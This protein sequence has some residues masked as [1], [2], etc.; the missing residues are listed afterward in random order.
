MSAAAALQHWLSAFE[1]SKLNPPDPLDPALVS[2]IREACGMDLQQAEL[3][4]AGGGC[5]NRSFTVRIHGQRYFIKLNSADHLDLF[6][7]EADG[8]GALARC[9]AFRVPSVLGHGA[10]EQLA[11]LLLEHIA[12]QPL[13]SAADAARFADAL[14]QLHQDLD[15]R[16]GWQR[17]NYIGASAQ[18]NTP[19]EGWAVFFVRCR[20]E[21]QLALARANGHGD[22]LGRD[23]VTLLERV[24]ALFLDY[25]PRPS[26]LHG[27][28][29]HGNAAIDEHGRPVIFDPAVYR[30]DRDADLAM[31]E[32]FG[33]FPT[34]F[35]ARYRAAWPLA[36]GYE[37]RKLLYNL[38]HILNHLNLFG[39]GYLGE[40]QRMLRTLVTQLGR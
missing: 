3:Q 40:A 24:P 20:L 12:L 37:Q 10:S 7:A 36:E 4:P 22:A 11:F 38:Y 15:T 8:L 33:G 31:S 5:I 6:E 34:A 26:L 30:G 16:F 17:D 23:A 13:S 19:N 1:D 14:V 21:P 28:L 29:W 9:S 18:C 27:D 25:R 32:L 39:R 2:A 35:Y